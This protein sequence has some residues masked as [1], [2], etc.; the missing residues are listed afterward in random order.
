[1]HPKQNRGKHCKSVYKCN[2][3]NLQQAARRYVAFAQSLESKKLGREVKFKFT[4]VAFVFTGVELF[5][6]LG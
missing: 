1:M 4:S 5:T 3:S 6:G 2:Y